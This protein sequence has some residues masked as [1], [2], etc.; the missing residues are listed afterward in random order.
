L[1]SPRSHSELAIA[2]TLVAVGLLFTGSAG[3]GGNAVGSS[4]LLVAQSPPPPA[5]GFGRG[6]VEVTPSGSVS[7]VLGQ[8]WYPVA[9]SAPRLV[10][11]GAAA[12]PTPARQL[13]I[14]G[15][16][17]SIPI[18]G[19]AGG[20]CASWSRGGRYLSYVTGQ[21][22]PYSTPRLGAFRIQGSL[23][24]V[25]PSNPTKPRRV[26]SGL[27]PTS[28]CP[29]WSQRS[30]KLAY[31]VAPA[32]DQAWRLRVFAGGRS[33][34]VAKLTDAVPSNDGRTF[35]WSRRQDVLAYV[36]G[37]HLSVYAGGRAR[38]VGR[39]A[40][41]AAL[42]AGATRRGESTVARAVELSPNG[43]LVAVEISQ[44]TAVFSLASGR[45]LG[46]AVGALYGW[47]GNVGVLSIALLPGRHG[48]AL[49][50]TTLA[51]KRTIIQQNTESATISDPAGGWFAHVVTVGGPRIVFRKPDGRVIRRVSLGFLPQFV[52]A[53]AADGTTETPTKGLIQ[54]A[55]P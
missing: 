24:V 42:L 31:V 53:V 44:R 19:S 34:S 47:A 30:A 50:L 49:L 33:A 48:P 5:P 15:P 37:R 27:F 14:V 38:A 23:W 12:A 40:I 1:F 25:S 52:Q 26:D 36:D 45:A 28:E 17:K 10:V 16:G 41:L 55:G 6:L 3:G 43:R 8:A 9:W 32:A 18:P 46:Q 51:G 39:T 22:S 7:R 2:C 11:A 35:A 54:T 20:R 13:T 21:A 4:F 29:L